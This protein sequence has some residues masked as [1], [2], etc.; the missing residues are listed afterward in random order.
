MD[1]ARGTNGPK[2]QMFTGFWQGNLQER[3]HF[4]D[5]GTEGRII[6]K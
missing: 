1:S 6:L 4:E 5:M 2:K 3:G